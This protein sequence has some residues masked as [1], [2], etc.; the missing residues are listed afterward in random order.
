MRRET[1]QCPCCGALLTT[2]ETTDEDLRALQPELAPMLDPPRRSLAELK[3]VQLEH[4]RDNAKFERQ[5]WPATYM[6]G[7]PMESNVLPFRYRGEGADGN[8]RED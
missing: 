8:E 4:M 3:R 2:H 1:F 5:P 7:S 6:D